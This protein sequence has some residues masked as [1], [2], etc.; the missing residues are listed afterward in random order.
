M[1]HSFQLLSQ[2]PSPKLI[3]IL[4]AIK[5]M[6]TGFSAHL[7]AIVQKVCKTAEN[8]CECSNHICD[9]TRKRVQCEMWVKLGQINIVPDKTLVA[10]PFCRNNC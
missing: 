4:L 2:V 8:H 6:L 1:Y 7:C 3:L 10:Y 9:G 5:N